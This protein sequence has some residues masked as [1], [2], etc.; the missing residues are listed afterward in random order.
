[1]EK[2]INLEESNVIQQQKAKFVDTLNERLNMEIE[3]KQQAEAKTK[4]ELNEKL[5]DNLD[6]VNK[7]VTEQINDLTAKSN[8]CFNEISDLKDKS[9]DI[10]EKVDSLKSGT[11]YF[12]ILGLGIKAMWYPLEIWPG[13]PLQMSNSND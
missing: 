7:A 2:I 13:N 4:E 9:Q 3:T 10:E 6:A 1:M 11:Y 8:D 12:Y 5:K